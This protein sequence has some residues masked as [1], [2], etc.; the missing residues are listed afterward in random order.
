MPTV[1]VPATTCAF[2]ITRWGAITNPLPSRDREHELALPR[3]LTTLPCNS[4]T[5]PLLC[6]AG[7][8]GE[9]SAVGAFWN[10]STI[11]GKPDASSSLRSWLGNPCAASGMVSLTL[12]STTELLIALASHGAP[13]T[14]VSGVAISHATTN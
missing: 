2:V 8:G 4:W 13:D 14:A 12:P 9:V 6:N 11:D 10:G 5:V 1:S 7:S 3:I